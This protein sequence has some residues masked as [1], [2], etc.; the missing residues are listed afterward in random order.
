M[1]SSRCSPERRT[2]IQLSE[3]TTMPQDKAKTS[4]PSN[5]KGISKMEAVRRALGRLGADA[6]PLTIQP[7]IQKEF[8][9]NMDANMISSY[10]SSANKKAAGQ[11]RLNRRGGRGAAGDF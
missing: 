4:K 11:S 1:A 6:K 2:T 8:G 9:I 5:S 7:Y 10:K 3:G